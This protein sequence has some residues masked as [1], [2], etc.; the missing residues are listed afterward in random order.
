MRDGQGCAAAAGRRLGRSPKESGAELTF[1]IYDRTMN[2]RTIRGVGFAI[3]AAACFGVTTPILASLQG[4][5]PPFVVSALI[6]TG[7][8]AAALL[9]ASLGRNG[10]TLNR[11]VLPRL[12]TSSVLG[13]VAAPALL[14]YGLTRADGVAACLLLNFEAVFTAFLGVLLYRERIGWRFAVGITAVTVGAVALMSDNAA[15]EQEFVGL[16]AVAGATGLWATDNAL[17]RP[18]A[19]F[20]SSQVMLVKGGVGASLSLVIA[21]GAGPMAIDWHPLV[22]VVLCGLL[23]Y[24]GMERFYLMAQRTLGVARTSSVFA[25]SPFFGAA[26]AL[27]SGLP[28]SNTWFVAGAVMAFGVYL[29]A[30]DGDLELEV[31]PEPARN[32]NPTAPPAPPRGPSSAW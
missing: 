7:M 8:I 20:D 5:L 26:V 28:A 4:G 32:K 23:G 24:G 14:T 13:A 30:T 10:P 21:L 12:V 9:S 16:L 22:I 1:V 17:N 31:Q 11:R 18:L 29:H 25:V 15:N 6:S 2:P 3:L 19:Q 27:A